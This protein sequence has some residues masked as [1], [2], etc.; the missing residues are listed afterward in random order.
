MLVDVKMGK[1]FATK[2]SFSQGLTLGLRD[3][4][5]IN[6]QSDITLLEV[7]LRW[8]LILSIDLVQHIYAAVGH[9]LLGA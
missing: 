7:S 9:D 8:N 1:R 4:S 3:V 5:R 6:T 2:V